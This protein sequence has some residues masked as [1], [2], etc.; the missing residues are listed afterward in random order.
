MIQLL[1]KYAGEIF[2]VHHAF[3]DIC[4]FWYAFLTKLCEREAKIYP[5]LNPD[6]IKSVLLNLANQTR[7]SKE[8]TGPITQNDLSNAFIEAAGI[9]PNDET[10][11]MLQRLPSLGRIKYYTGI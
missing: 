1:L 8:N 4:G 2:S 10:A 3:E 9:T 5:A 11:I 6:T 7:M